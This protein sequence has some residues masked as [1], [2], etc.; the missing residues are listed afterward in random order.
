VTV[1]APPGLYSAKGTTLISVPDTV[2]HLEFYQS[3][4][5]TGSPQI[6]LTIPGSSDRPLIIDGCPYESCQ[7]VHTGSRAIV[8]RDTTLHSYTAQNGAGDLYIEDSILSAA[9][10]GTTVNFYQSQKIWARQLNLEEQNV[11]KFNC[12]GCSIWILGYKT[13]QFTPSIVLANRARAEVFGF[14]FY[15]IEA[16]TKEGTANIYLTDSSLFATGWTQVDVPGRGQPNW[17]IERQGGTA[18]SLPTRDINTSQQLNMYYSY[19]GGGTSGAQ[20]LNER[21][22]VQRQGDFS[23]P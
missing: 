5:A 10:I 20:Q 22:K 6:I 12:S 3:K 16:P 4:F 7:I 23:E 8:L 1:Y 13:E 11:S 17:V 9:P 14:F 15:Q 21:G 19:G 2:S 18:S